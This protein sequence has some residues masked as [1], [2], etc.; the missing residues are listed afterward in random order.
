MRVADVMTAN[1]ERVPPDT[2]IREAAAKMRD[3][4]VG[5]IPVFE[6]DRLI[7][8]VTDRDIAI[9]GFADG[10]AESRTVREVMTPGI[11]YCFEDQ[12]IREAGKLMRERKVRRQLLSR[13]ILSLA[14]NG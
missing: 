10:G 14:H 7:G 4:D 9:R 8:M 12:D 5:A 2:S 11:S 1:V 6:D 13:Y 3:L